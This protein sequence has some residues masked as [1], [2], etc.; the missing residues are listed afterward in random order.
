LRFD[1]LLLTTAPVDLES[2]AMTSW[3][4][5]QVCRL[6]LLDRGHVTVIEKDLVRPL[7][8]TVC[9]HPRELNSARA[10]IKIIGSCHRDHG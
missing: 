6:T 1:Q 10:F 7:R 3:S 9:D 2:E 4:H 8:V 5:V